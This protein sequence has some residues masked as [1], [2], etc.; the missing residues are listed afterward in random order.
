M[1]AVGKGWGTVAIAVYPVGCYMMAPLFRQFLNGT[2]AAPCV[3]TAGCAEGT[4]PKSPAE[5]CPAANTLSAQPLVASGC[6][7]CAEAALSAATVC[8]QWSFLS[9]QQSNEFRVLPGGAADEWQVFETGVQTFH[10]EGAVLGLFF[11][12]TF[13]DLPRLMV[14]CDMVTTDLRDKTNT[15]Y[16]HVFPDVGCANSLFAVDLSFTNA[17]GGV[18]AGVEGANGCDRVRVMVRRSPDRTFTLKNFRLLTD[19]CKPG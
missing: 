7:G 3:E 8:A 4:T 1:L 12:T 19:G 18:W 16:R 14:E 6:K 15:L 10:D 11:E 13:R 17:L 2:V 5:L 9:G